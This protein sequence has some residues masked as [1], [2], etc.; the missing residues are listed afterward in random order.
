MN[1]PPAPFIGAL[2]VPWLRPLAQA[3][4]LLALA[5]GL[6]AAAGAGLTRFDIAIAIFLGLFLL[7]RQLPF[8]ATAARLRDVLVAETVLSGLIVVA[9]GGWSSAWLLAHMVPLG[10]AALGVSQARALSMGLVSTALITVGTIGMWPEPRDLVSRISTLLLVVVFSA[11]ARHI[12]SDAVGPSDESIGEVETLWNVRALLEGLHTQVAGSRARFNVGEALD[13]IRRGS[14]ALSAA[15]LVAVLALQE[16]GTLRTLHGIGLP[17]RTVRMRD[18]PERVLTPRRDGEPV[19][20]A[21]PHGGL[22]TDATMGAYI[23]LPVPNDEPQHI[24]VVESVA[25]MAADAVLPELARVAQPLAI[26]ISNAAWFSRVR[27]LGVDEERQ[28][29]A[30][31]LHDHF[32]QSLAVVQLELELAL[33]RHP[34]DEG[35]VGL[36]QHVKGT[37]GDLRDTM[38]ELRATVD[39]EHPLTE[40]LGSL[41]QRLVDRHGI[42]AELTLE[43]EGERPMPAVEQ[44]LLRI[45]QELTRRAVAERGAIAVYVHYVCDDRQL[46]LEVTDDG[47]APTPDRLRDAADVIWERAEAIGATVE[48]SSAGPGLSRVSV[49]ASR[50]AKQS[51]ARG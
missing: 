28:R 50:V 9:T 29:I 27:H 49:A 20:L 18:L 31:R 26:T 42:M 39:D 34:E 40:V 48:A 41:V 35:L 32:A 13:A 15:D 30:A 36:K 47:E 43:G 6:L 2:R 14:Q 46:L 16:D 19:A 11:I 8:S 12:L 3:L 24:L 1:D 38:V 33:R 10:L 17:S 5:I 22:L 25:E 4:R 7:W 37:L 45:A 21:L 23:W 51:G 44:Q